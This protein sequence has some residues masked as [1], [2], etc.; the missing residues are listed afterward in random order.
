[1]SKTVSTM[2]IALLAL[3]ILYPIGLVVYQS[4]LDNPFFQPNVQ[5][6]TF[7][8]EFVFS[9]PDFWTAV[10]NSV[11]IAVGMTLIAVPVGG[12]LAFVMTRTD[13]PFRRL[14]EGFI[15]TPLFIS[16]MILA[17]GYVVSAGP[18]GIFSV[19]FESIFGFVPW[20][21]Y[22]KTTF[23]VIA[24]LTHVPHAYIYA[25]AA[26]QNLGSDVEEAAR[27]SGAGP[28]RVALT[29][30]LPMIL[31]S[32]LFAAV[33]IFFMGFEMFGL[34]LILGDPE[35]ITVIATYLYKLTN[36]LGTPSYQLMAA[37]VVFMLAVTLPLVWIQRKML[38]SANKYISVKGKAAAQ[39]PL[40][41][42]PWRWVAFALILLWMFVTV[43]VPVA[44]LI[45]RSVLSTWG[46]GVSIFE[47][48]TLDH[49]RQLFQFPQITRS[50]VNT[51]L[52][53]TLGGAA[54]VAVYT[55]L[56][57][58]VGRKTEGA[59]KFVDYIVMLPRAMPG[60]I[61]GLAI[62]WVFL[63]TPI[64]G[65][66]RQTLVSVWTAYTLVWLAYGLRLITTSFMQISPDLQEAARVA[67]ASAGRV[68]RDI[69]LPLARAGIIGSW[70]LIFIAFTREYS[71]G[72]YLLSPGSETIGALLV[73][74]WAGGNI[75][76]VTALA[77]V[78]LGF[79]IVG[80]A[81]LWKFGDR[82]NG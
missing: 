59:A 45:L 20:Y 19:W 54:A 48:M 71:T 6:S 41:L 28:A 22:S 70:L 23:I 66:M 32:L 62:F 61:A 10:W 75:N 34:A 60:L 5:W 7:G 15:L 80:L 74:L 53:A 55:L 56:A 21:L 1:M 18:V 67:G 58:A 26:L 47:V 73:S 68:S 81:M 51:L 39:R 24:G 36:I 9:D 57:L 16:P 77:T 46:Q 4:F 30:S 37:V 52:M 79:I 40:K 76:A 49:F 43:I 14:V 17:F 8:Y 63:F 69:T 12:L 29:V 44:G 11:Q 27:I 65:D 72:V 31:P 13:V 33:L 78:N 25:S 82:R 38:R 2:V 42:G 64:L 3:A 35:G 50:M